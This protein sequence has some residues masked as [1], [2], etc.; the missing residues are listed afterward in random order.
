MV[1]EIQRRNL[2]AAAYTAQANSAYRFDWGLDGLNCL[3][4]GA[5]VVVIVDVLRFT[6]AVSAAVEVGATVL[7]YR[8]NDDQAPAY[9][10]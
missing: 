3:A 1:A 8:W 9:A 6:T 7:P 10:A 4:P 2:P 5:Q